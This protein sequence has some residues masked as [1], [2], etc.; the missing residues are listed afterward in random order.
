[1]GLL[2]LSGYHLVWLKVTAYEYSKVLLLIY[3]LYWWSSLPKGVRPLLVAL[4]KVEEVDLVLVQLD[5]HPLGPGHHVINILLH[6][7]VL[8]LL[9]DNSSSLFIISEFRNKWLVFYF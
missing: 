3:L 4:S 5:A 2:H 9:I 1:M 8:L 7:N 6:S